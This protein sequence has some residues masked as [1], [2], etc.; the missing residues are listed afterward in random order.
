MLNVTLILMWMWGFMGWAGTP[1][2]YCSPG[3][4][5]CWVEVDF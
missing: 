4:M 5:T 3:G 2:V 1:S